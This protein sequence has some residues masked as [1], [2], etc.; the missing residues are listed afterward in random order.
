[1]PP[2]TPRRELSSAEWSLIAAVIRAVRH[3][4]VTVISVH[5]GPKGAVVD[6]AAQPP[7]IR[8]SAIEKERS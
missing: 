5:H 7:P 8:A 4:G 1:L 2:V 3:P 6:V